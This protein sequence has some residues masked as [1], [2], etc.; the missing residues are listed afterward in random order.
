MPVAI[1]ILPPLIP[2]IKGEGSHLSIVSYNNQQFISSICETNG[3]QG[4]YGLGWKGQML[5]PLDKAFKNEKQ[6]NSSTNYSEH[7]SQASNFTPEL[8]EIRKASTDINM[9]LS[10]LVLN[11]LITAARKNAAEFMPVLEAIKQIG[12]NIAYIFTESVDSLQEVTV[13]SSHLDNAGF[14]AALAVDIMDRNL[15]ERANDCRWW[16]L[17]TEFKHL[18]KQ[19]HITNEDK[20]NISN[21][22]LYINDLYTVYTNLY[23]YGSNGEILAVSNKNEQ[24]LIGQQLTEQTGALS[25]L[26]I[27]DSQKYTV[28]AFVKS[29]LYSDRHTYIYNASITDFH[30]P[31]NVLGGIGIVFDSESQFQTMLEDILPRDKKNQIVVGCFAMFVDR[32]KKII[33]IANHPGF[34]CN[35]E[36]ELQDHYFNLEAGKRTSEIIDFMGQK[37]ILGVAVAQ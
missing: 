15:Y 2:T 34:S 3:Y 13:I 21:I 14:L 32:N 4:F 11:G 36:L 33:S 27:N 20:Q 37:Y 1:Q 22:L 23:V 19:A 5:T 29:P 10:L 31:S 12:S 17:T 26:K 6:K 16:A 28:S 9:D 35:D 18:L 8:E 7:I 25:A 30:D 24:N